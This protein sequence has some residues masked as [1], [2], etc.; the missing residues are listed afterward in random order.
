MNNT[1]WTLINNKPLYS[2]VVFLLLA[3]GLQM[4]GK[5]PEC[6][7]DSGH[8]IVASLSSESNAGSLPANALCSD[9][10]KGIQITH[11]DRKSDFPGRESLKDILLSPNETT[12][13]QAHPD[14]LVLKS[15]SR[16]YLNTYES[17]PVIVPART[18]DCI[19][20]FLSFRVIR[21]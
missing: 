14:K 4:L 19:P 10:Q 21:I 3:A 7:P 17:L 13:F 12:H 11:K 2:V 8:L 18:R 15:F 16:K 9:R 6:R 1:G 20:Y 5:H